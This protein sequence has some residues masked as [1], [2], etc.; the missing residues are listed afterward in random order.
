[1]TRTTIDFGIDLGTTNSAIAVLVDGRPLPIRNNEQQEL[2]PSA[3]M[4]DKNGAISVGQR[5]YRQAEHRPSA[6]AREFK[7]AMG[8]DKVISLSGRN[9]TPAELAAH[10]VRALRADA[11]ARYAEDVRAAVISV[12]AMF[13]LA[14]CDATRRAAQ[15]AGIEQ[16]LLLQE[17]IAAG[18]AYGVQDAGANGYWLVY[19]LGGGTFDASLV[20]IQDRRMMVVDHAGDEWLGGKNFDDILVDYVGDRLRHTYR[21]DGPVR[22]SQSRYRTLYARLKVACEEAKV[23]LS[24][25]EQAVVDVYGATDDSGEPIDT[26]VDVPRAT[27]ERLIH[28]LVART[29]KI[30]GDL[31]EQNR[32]RPATVQGVIMVGGPTLTPFIRD[33]ITND[34]GI[35]IETRIDPMTVV[36]QGAA[37]FAGSVLRE[38]P[39][40]VSVT[41][42]R[43]I[44]GLDLKYEPTSD[45]DDVPVGGRLAEQPPPGLTIR[46]ERTDGGWSSGSVSVQDGTFVMTVALRPWQANTFTLRLFD[47]T[48]LELAASPNQFTIRHGL[49]VDD[50]PLSRSLGVAVVDGGADSKTEFLL[51]RGTR[52]PASAHRIFRTVRPIATRQPA[53]INIHVVE[54]EGRRADRNDHVGYVRLDGTNIARPL[55]VGSEVDISFRLDVSRRLSV[56]VFVPLL[57]HTSMLRVEDVDRPIPDAEILECQLRAEEARLAEVESVASIGEVPALVHEVRRALSD[58]R[59]G[60]QD[61]AVQA[62]RRLREVQILLD[63]AVEDAGLPLL[64]AR[65]RDTLSKTQRAAAAYGQP[66][67]RRQLGVLQREGEQALAAGSHAQLRLRIEELAK[68]YWGAVT[69]YDGW[70]I[71]FFH[72]LRARQRVATE[73]ATAQILIQQGQGAL[74][75]RD[76]DVLRQTCRSLWGLLADIGPQG[77]AGGLPDV[78]VRS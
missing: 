34:T 47:A 42:G 35:E 69:T 57:E 60:D 20:T 7:R 17:P 1:M 66:S 52:L 53:G 12:P 33:R 4:V 46:A 3:V 76:F 40:L 65:W 44:I 74:D 9:M 71:T 56:E 26:Y 64:Q 51:K 55:P 21:V 29:T 45:D 31:L 68:L 13:T 27:Y 37:L 36:A 78:G 58:A 59:A 14:A 72:H 75:R 43:D 25:D 5:A 30:V 70:W 50:P 48:G 15:L 2:T 49:V 32:V 23:R 38:K 61:A 67:D 24:R 19:D 8:T 11:Q 63:A 62:Q 54:G 10:V 77:W 73:P 6:V 18:I 39:T 16:C 41:E 22:P 28:P